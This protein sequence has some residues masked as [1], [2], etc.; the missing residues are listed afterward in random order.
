MTYAKLL[1]WEKTRK[2]QFWSSGTVATL[3]ANGILT[4]VQLN[5]AFSPVVFTE[6]SRCSRNKH[7]AKKRPPSSIPVSYFPVSSQALRF[8]FVMLVAHCLH[9]RIGASPKLCLWLVALKLLYKTDKTL[10][11][12]ENHSFLYF[13]TFVACVTPTRV[14][15]EHA[16][17]VYICSRKLNQKTSILIRFVSCH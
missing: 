1:G 10:Y 2:C 12:S 6:A 7:F 15:F 13:H 16:G 11:K 3:F 8:L 4:S 9:G 14:L 5:E 17:M